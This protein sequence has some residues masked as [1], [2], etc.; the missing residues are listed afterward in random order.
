M[1]LTMQDVAS[2]LEQPNLSDFSIKSAHD[3]HLLRPFCTLRHPD[4]LLNA[5]EQ[6]RALAVVARLLNRDDAARYLNNV[7]DGLS[8]AE[9]RI[10]T[11]CFNRWKDPIKDAT[12]AFH[13][14]Q[15]VEETL[16]EY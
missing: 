9:K 10:L 11:A 2:Q 3:A 5:R 13:R 4:S 12:L 8:K 7:D 16:L 6:A 1:A 15:C 14:T